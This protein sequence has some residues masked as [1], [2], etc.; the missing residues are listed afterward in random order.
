M[1]L[2]KKIINKQGISCSE[3]LLLLAIYLD[4]S[5]NPSNLKD[6]EYI[7]PLIINGKTTKRFAIT[8][9]G[10]KALERIDSKSFN[11]LD[12]IDYKTLCTEM[13]ELF[14]KG[15]KPGTNTPWREPVKLIERRLKSFFKRFG[16]YS[17]EEILDATRRYI[18]SYEIDDRYMRTVRYFIF[19]Y[20]NVDGLREVR[21]D[22]LVYLE[23]KTLGDRVENFTDDWLID[24][25]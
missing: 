18:N 22:L 12:T 20:E 16:M 8:E 23:D 17:E 9:E 7:E 4:N 24:M 1:R 14:P 21:S 25:V 19:K 11:E 5:I 3:Y 10:I 6:L 2:D 15:M 13:R